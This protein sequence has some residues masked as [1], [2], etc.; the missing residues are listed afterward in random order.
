MTSAPAN[1]REQDQVRL[2][3][4]LPVITALAY[5]IEARFEA[6][7][8][9][10]DRVAADLAEA[11]AAGE[12]GITEELAR[13]YDNTAFVTKELLETA[14]MADYG[15]E[16]GRRKMFTLIRDM[17]STPTLPAA[18][19]APCMDVLLKLSNGERDFQRVVVE[20]VQNVR[21]MDDAVGGAEE[22]E[23]QEEDDDELDL[24]TATAEDIA[25]AHR[26]KLEKA[27][28]KIQNQALDPDK[29]ETYI[30]CLNIV[31]AL[32]ER[33]TGASDD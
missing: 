22:A 8:D 19:I 1:D 28:K 6:L 7:L 29:K 12:E 14:L 15:D 20:I 23:G 5:R 3:A 4:C 30:R 16:I 25:E 32:L 26:R 18:L 10:V 24:A 31:K 13:E 9:L 33:V 17:I 27:A 2:E 21:E 11:Q